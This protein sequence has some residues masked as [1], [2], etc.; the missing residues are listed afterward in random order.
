ME[1]RGERGRGKEV[2]QNLNEVGKVGR[3]RDDRQRKRKIRA[4][5]NI[6]SG[7]MKQK[8]RQRRAG[9]GRDERRQRKRH[10]F[11]R[12]FKSSLSTNAYP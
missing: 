5:R 11:F 1:R 2:E 8:T 9:E 6:I 12:L 7:K 10:R 3:V 4:D